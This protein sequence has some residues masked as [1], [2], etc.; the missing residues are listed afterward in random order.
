M[1]GARVAEQLPMPRLHSRGP[2]WGVRGVLT[3]SLRLACLARHGKRP[4][5]KRWGLPDL[6]RELIYGWMPLERA[7]HL[8]VFSREEIHS[9]NLQ[10]SGEVTI[11]RDETC[12]VHI[13]DPAV[14]RRHAILRLGEILE[15]EDLGGPNGTFVR[16][17]AQAGSNN[18]TVHVNIQ[19]LVRRK[20]RFVV[21]DCLLF[22]QACVVLRHAPRIEIPDLAPGVVVSDPAM[23]ALYAQAARVARANIN[24]LLLGETGV[25]KE[26]LARALHAHSQRA[27]GLF[28]GINCAA[29]ADSLL[30]SE[31]FGSEKGAFT[32]ATTRAGLFEAAN[33]GTVFLDE[34]GELPLATQAKLLRVLEER[35][36]TRLGSTRSRP[37]DVRIVAAT[38]RDLES[39][40][41]QG[42]MRQDL[43]FR[44]NGVSLVVPALRERPQEIDALATSFL[45]ATCRDLERV[46]LPAI[47]SA[48][49]DVLRRYAWPGNVR[50][51]RNVIERAA[52]MCSE[53]AIL[54][55]HLPASLLAAIRAQVQQKPAVSSAV[56]GQ[57]PNLQAEKKSFEQDKILE[58]LKRCGGNQ[59]EAARQ[60]GMPRRTLVARLSELGLTR[61]LARSE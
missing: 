58:A 29:L 15:V 57:P 55:E 11:G 53:S 46:P 47:S 7:Y 12:T 18:D 23:Q 59:S 4:N 41:R 20:S 45:A 42:R 49:L 5:C 26:V 32:G 43:Y 6:G 40:C 35:V 19:Q 50:E 39:D 8:V 48:A 22:G 24:V 52:V 25:G 61:R 1:D 16:H 37:I 9:Y 10:V 3:V 38:N 51:L 56:A 27:Q 28:V 17:M 2:G 36:V 44:I 14:S 54:P 34:I 60:L 31:L 33:C 13:N 21:G 30:E